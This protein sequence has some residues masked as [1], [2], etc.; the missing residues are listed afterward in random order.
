RVGITAVPPGRLL[1]QD[2][3]GAVAGPQYRGPGRQ[4][5]FWPGGFAPR[6]GK[7]LLVFPSMARGA[8]PIVPLLPTGSMVT[9]PRNDTHYLATEY[10]VVDVKGLSSRERAEAIIGL[11]HPDVRADLTRA[12][13]D[14][15][16]L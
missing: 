16:L 5:R 4:L 2:H 15:Y 6:G 12:A 14:L 13:E 8:S 10:G 1:G 9:T 11:A 3:A 7:S